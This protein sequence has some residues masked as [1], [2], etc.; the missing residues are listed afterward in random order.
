MI[1]S[2]WDTW[3]KRAAIAHRKAQLQKQA[4]AASS[5]SAPSAPKQDFEL[6]D[7]VVPKGDKTQNAEQDLED[8][9]KVVVRF[10]VEGND[11]DQSEDEDLVW[12]RLATKVGLLKARRVCNNPLTLVSRFLVRLRAVGRL[13]MRNMVKPS[14]NGIMLQFDWR[15]VCVLSLLHVLYLNTSLCIF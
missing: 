11:R 4:E 2:E 8:D 5:S 1:A 7:K 6:E 15:Y 14:L 10:F 9:I 3:R 13:S 12:Q